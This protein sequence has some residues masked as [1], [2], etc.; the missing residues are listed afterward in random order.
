MLKSI[1]LKGCSQSVLTKETV[2][3]SGIVSIGS[4]KEWLLI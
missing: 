2:V 4:F 1:T 3:I